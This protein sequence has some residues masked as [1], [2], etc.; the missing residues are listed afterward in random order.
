MAGASSTGPPPGSAGSSRTSHVPCLAR[1][2]MNELQE[3]G[4]TTHAPCGHS[5]QSWLHQV[6]EPPSPHIWI[7]NEPPRTEP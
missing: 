3:H 4:L 2:C 7:T 5:P 6:V 1:I